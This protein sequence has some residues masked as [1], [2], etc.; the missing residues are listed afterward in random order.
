MRYKKKINEKTFLPNIEPT[1]KY[2]YE[3]AKKKKNKK[4]TDILTI[5]QFV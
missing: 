3:E 4:K 1:N 2:K 5:G